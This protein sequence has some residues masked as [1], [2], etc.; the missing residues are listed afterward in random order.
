MSS[1]HRSLVRKPGR[2]R[3]SSWSTGAPPTSSAARPVCRT[4]PA[5]CRSPLALLT[6][7]A[8]AG[9]VDEG[10]VAGGRLGDVDPPQGRS[11]RCGAMKRRPAT[12][13]S[14]PRF[15]ATSSDSTPRPRR[16]DPI[17][18]ISGGDDATRVAGFNMWDDMQKSTWGKLALVA[19]LLGVDIWAV[20][21][22]I[23]GLAR[24]EPLKVVGSME[25]HPWFWLLV[26]CISISMTVVLGGAMFWSRARE[27]LPRHRFRRLHG[28]IREFRDSFVRCFDADTDSVKLDSEARER[29]YT[30]KSKLRA[31]RIETPAEGAGVTE[32]YRWLPAAA[33]WADTK[34]VR[35][36][37]AYRSGDFSHPAADA[38]AERLAGCLVDRPVV[39]PH[40]P[41][42]W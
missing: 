39:W 17:A 2:R 35:A 24:G 42:G 34:N 15:R 5:A 3:R 32:W 6:C 10:P 21:A 1:A 40:G 37:R 19:G 25:L 33:S 28:E 22:F 41:P 20:M 30:L 12:T 7:L 36:A 31:L 14:R 26:A 11:P 8:A 27:R 38:H 13:A 16:R 29:L 23:R 18:V 9:T 4:W